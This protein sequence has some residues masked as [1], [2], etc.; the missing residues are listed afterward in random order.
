MTKLNLDFFKAIKTTTLWKPSMKTLFFIWI[1]NA[2]WCAVLSLPSWFAPFYLSV[3]SSLELSSRSEWTFTSTLK[4]TFFAVRADHFT[5]SHTRHKRTHMHTHTHSP[6][7]LPQPCAARIDSVASAAGRQRSHIALENF[8]R[9]RIARLWKLNRQTD[10][11]NIPSFKHLLPESLFF[12]P[13][14]SP[15]SDTW[16]PLPE[17]GKWQ[18]WICDVY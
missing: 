10:M 11:I 14:Y 9:A 5:S 15:L 7:S 2:E 13:T 8:S 17:M 6:P 1:R 3:L 18:K 16:T 12:V 4:Q